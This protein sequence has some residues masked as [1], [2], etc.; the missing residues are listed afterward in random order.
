M[1]AMQ[2]GSFITNQGLSDQETSSRS[3]EFEFHPDYEDPPISPKLASTD[4]SEHSA[5]LEGY[6][7]A[8]SSTAQSSDTYWYVDLDGVSDACTTYDQKNGEVQV[9]PQV[10]LGIHS[11]HQMHDESD[12][13]RLRDR[14]EKRKDAEWIA[15]V[16]LKATE[17]GKEDGGHPQLIEKWS[18][19]AEAAD[20]VE[21]DDDNMPKLGI[22]EGNTDLCSLEL[23]GYHL[24]DPG[25]DIDVYDDDRHLHTIPMMNNAQR[26]NSFGV[27]PHSDDSVVRKDNRARVEEEDGEDVVADHPSYCISIFKRLSSPPRP[28]KSAASSH[29]CTSSSHV[30]SLPDSQCIS[31]R[32]SLKL[33][34][35]LRKARPRMAS[36]CEMKPDEEINNQK[37]SSSR[38]H[39]R[40]ARPARMQLSN[41]TTALPTYSK[42]SISQEQKGVTGQEFISKSGASAS[43]LGSNVLAR[44]AQYYTQQRARIEQTTKRTFLPYRQTLL[45]GST[46]FLSTTAHPVLAH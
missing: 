10:D 1:P 29:I 16:S 18:A 40:A 23:D 33:H 31:R 27:F 39:R 37:G 19:R 30:A 3:I 13:L 22:Q 36:S 28:A 14:N 42:S 24:N 32:L 5:T 45:F 2:L 46:I 6:V 34:V 8:V 21:M 4:F 35:L 44:H 38:T 11:P 9:R 20:V 15:E 25:K 17:L 41:E 43:I 7:Y 26:G 12:R